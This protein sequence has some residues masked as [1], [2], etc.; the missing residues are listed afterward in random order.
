MQNKNI[1]LHIEQLILHGFLASD[2]HRI[3][4]AVERELTNLLTDKGISPPMS[5]DFNAVSLDGGTIEISQNS[6]AEK[7]GSQVAHSI[8]KGLNR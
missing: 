1:E 2:R 3:A 4:G 5:K 7:V 8:Y 6:P